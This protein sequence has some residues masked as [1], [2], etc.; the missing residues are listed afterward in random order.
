MEKEK[1][2]KIT[3]EIQGRK[4]VLIFA[5]KAN[6]CVPEQVKQMLLSNYAQRQQQTKSA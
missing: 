5:D 6:P 2:Q 4:V 1:T 3:T